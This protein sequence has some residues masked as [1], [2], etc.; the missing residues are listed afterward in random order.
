MR[1]SVCS[2]PGFG[3]HCH[4]LTNPYFSPKEC[5]QQWGTT[6][7]WAPQFGRVRSYK[8][9]FTIFFSPFSSFCVFRDWRGIAR[10]GPRDS[11][12]A[13]Y[14]AKWDDPSAVQSE[15]GDGMPD[16]AFF[17]RVIFFLLFFQVD[18][19]Y[20]LPDG[21]TL[22]RM[23]VVYDEEKRKFMK[24]PLSASA[25]SLREKLCPAVITSLLIFINCI[26]ILLFHL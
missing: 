6:K 21:F 5:R 26:I 3:N 1:V 19:N 23:A 14:C 2:T 24:V 20:R 17:T 12:S 9:P 11:Q 18:L 16:Q 15:Q 8:F 10:N 7:R 4:R 22:S 13:T 25:E